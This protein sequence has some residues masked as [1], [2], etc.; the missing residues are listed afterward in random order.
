MQNTNI[1][2]PL[3]VSLRRLEHVVAK[4][5]GSTPEI[6][7]HTQTRGSIRNQIRFMPPFDPQQPS[8]KDNPWHHDFKREAVWCEANEKENMSFVTLCFLDG[9]GGSWGWLYYLEDPDMEH[10]KTLAPATHALGVAMGRRLVEFFGGKVVYDDSKDT[11]DYEVEPAKA[12]FPTIKKRQTS[13]DRWYQ[14][15]NALRAL[16]PLRALELDQAAE[17]I[18]NGALS[19][20]EKALKAYLHALERTETLGTALPEAPQTRAAK[21]RF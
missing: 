18:P 9:A 14:F 21:P 8:A 5:A 12:L 13:N 4:L 16:P 1:H 11:I 15:E 19:T 10:H 3:S 2:L 7:V 17:L 20:K 6:T